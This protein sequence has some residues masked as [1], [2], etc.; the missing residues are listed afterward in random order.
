MAA[1]IF[2]V[3]DV[4]TRVRYL[5][6]D[7]T[8]ATSKVYVWLTD[9]LSLLFSVCPKARKNESINLEEY[10]RFTADAD[11]VPCHIVYLPLLADYVT[12]R[13]LQED[14]DSQEH[15]ARAAEHFK[16]FLDTALL[17]EYGMGHKQTQAPITGVR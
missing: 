17:L 11:V 6:S 14:A 3:A 9:G 13:A 12:C 2:T 1:P 5:K 8:Y 16:L 15:R 7:S 10:K 4:T